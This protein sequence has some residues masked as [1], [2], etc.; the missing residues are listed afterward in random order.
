MAKT[1]KVLVTAALKQCIN[2]IQS[3][4]VYPNKR[5]ETVCSM[6]GPGSHDSDLGEQQTGCGAYSGWDNPSYPRRHV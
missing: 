5:N 1:Q 2:N 6:Q 4:L 3:V